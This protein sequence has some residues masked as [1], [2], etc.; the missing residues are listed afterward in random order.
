M[1]K[2]LKSLF[3][4]D[5]PSPSYPV[6][7]ALN[8]E[9]E[10]N[11][12]GLYMA[13]EIAGKPLIKIALNEGYNIASI[14]FDKLK[15][16]SNKNGDYDVVIIGAGISGI[17]AAVRLNELGAKVVA[18]DSGKCFQTLRNFTRGKL[19]LAEPAEI[20]LKGSIP[21][22]EGSVEETL[23]NFD[24]ALITN[25]VE[26]R[27]YTKVSD[28]Q[29]KNGLFTVATDRGEIRAELV[30]LSTGKAGNPRKAG[31]PGELEWANKIFHFLKDP[32]EYENLNLLIYGGGDVAAEAALA[33]CDTNN[34]TLAAVDKD[35][36]FPKKK[37][38]DNMRKKESKGKLKILMETRL[39]K[40]GEKN[41]IL[42]NMATSEESNISNDYLFEMIGAEPPVSFFKKI[43][44]S[45]EN[46]WSFNKKIALFFA[47][48]IVLPLYTWKKGLWP[49]HYY[50]E[51]ISHLPVIFK[52]PSFWYS[53]LYTLVMLGFGLFAMKR[54]SNGWKDKYQ[55]YRFSSLIIF[56]ILSFFIIECML[57]LYL[58]S[59]TWWRAYAITN[60]F[61]LL[62]DSFYN[63]SGTS[64]SD[65]KWI[66]AAVG[67]FVTFVAIPISARYHGKRF[68]SWICG[69][70]GLAETLG[71]RWRHLSP[72]GAKSRRW[73]FMGMAVLFWAITSAFVILVFY[74]GDI[75][76][77]GIWHKSYGII[78]DFWLIAVIPMAFY[79]VLGGKLWCRY[80][81]PLA[82]YMELLSEKYGTLKIKSNDKCIQCTQCSLYCQVGVDV[83]AFAKNGEE[84]S[85]KNTSCIHC[86]V[87]IS[88]CPM[89]VL[90][91][92]N[93]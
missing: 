76:S 85:N 92:S 33:L 52:N 8:A 27:E 67:F 62:F 2:Y 36:I 17:A 60:P 5:S 23:V 54:W 84:F 40:V 63:L 75:G 21:F 78:V 16:G 58:P 86:G 90:S 55:I 74:S 26:Y 72:K 19:I 18:L 77:S 30:L 37:N 45:L 28:I 71:D 51:G 38:I 3:A 91:F 88:V 61:P 29:K 31:V 34:V 24:K 64:L 11:I 57:A 15:S 73:E 83:M 22:K 89:D 41:V 47:C 1:K 81:C 10:S 68:C 46:K 79:P 4:K 53:G 65:L 6:L 56:Q 87:C 35:F 70:G 50:G 20:K 48:M 25:G 39:K 13:G 14:L 42:E 49:F 44:I 32:D 93:D 69:C 82:K 7:P 59:D 43:G 80:W 66:I 12:K 9:G